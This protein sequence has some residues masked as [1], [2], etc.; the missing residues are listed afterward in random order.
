MEPNYV[1]AVFKWTQD[2]INMLPLYTRRGATSGVDG[3]G[4]RYSYDLKIPFKNSTF[5]GYGDTH[6][7]ARQMAAQSAYKYYDI[8]PRYLELD[9]NQGSNPDVVYAMAKEYLPDFVVCKIEKSS[10]VYYLQGADIGHHFISYIYDVIAGDIRCCSENPR[11]PWGDEL[12]GD[13]RLVYAEGIGDYVLM[14]YDAGKIRLPDIYVRAYESLK[15]EQLRR[16]SDFYKQKKWKYVD[17]YIGEME[18]VTKKLEDEIMVSMGKSGPKRRCIIDYLQEHG[19][20]PEP[21]DR[22]V[23]YRRKDVMDTDVDDA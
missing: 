15:E 11:D 21:D 4:Y 2:V 5:Y 18:T 12:I 10:G 17:K 13:P 19:Y 8:N 22:A 7:E 3:K 9:V 16:K 23:H 20:Y 1:Y 14:Q 6:V